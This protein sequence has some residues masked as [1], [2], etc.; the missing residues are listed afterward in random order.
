MYVSTAWPSE[1][2]ERKIDHLLRILKG[3]FEVG[4]ARFKSCVPKFTD[5]YSHGYFYENTSA[6]VH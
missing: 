3:N 2:V 1:I 6:C 4:Y 5:P